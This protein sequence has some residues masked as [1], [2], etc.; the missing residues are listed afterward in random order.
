[1]H[2]SCFYFHIVFCISTKKRHL[3]PSSM[4]FL[5]QRSLRQLDVQLQV[6]CKC[7]FEIDQIRCDGW[8][9]IPI[10]EKTNKIGSKTVLRNCQT[11]AIFLNNLKASQD[12]TMP[13]NSLKV[14][15]IQN[16]RN[17][18]PISKHNAKKGCSWVVDGQ[19][20]MSR[21]FQR[22]TMLNRLLSCQIL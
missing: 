10:N 3:K 12:K 21:H 20:A 18:I 9:G 8:F 6:N 22:K 5:T 15:Y 17:G 11:A 1:M 19:S 4:I 13:M 2:F 16:D 7:C 14:G